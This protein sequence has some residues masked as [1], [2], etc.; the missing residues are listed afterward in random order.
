MKT[1]N[2]QKTPRLRYDLILISVLLFIALV[3]LAVSLLTRVEG[4]YVEITDHGVLVATYPL[5]RDGEY[6]LGDGS[7]T[8]V[9][10]NGRAYMTYANCP[11]QHCV[12]TGKIGYVGENIICA[13]N[14]IIITV[15]GDSD[16]GVDFVS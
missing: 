13:Y 5:S 1:D 6:K 3:F 14:E 11:G 8:L 2:T 7:N 9:I 10:K 4:S 15:I 16:D 12:K